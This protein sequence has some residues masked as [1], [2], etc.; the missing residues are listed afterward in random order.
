M[1][2]FVLVTTSFRKS[3]SLLP[4]VLFVASEIPLDFYLQEHY[5]GA[6][7]VAPWV[8]NS[9]GLL[10]HLPAVIQFVVGGAADALILACGTLWLSRL[11]AASFVR[12]KKS[13][14][15]PALIYQ[16]L[17]TPDRTSEHVAKPNRDTGFYVLR[18]IGLIYALYLAI[19]L[20]GSL[21]SAG[22]PKA[23][24]PLVDQSYE[25]IPLVIN[26]YVKLVLMFLL[27]TIAAYNVKLRYHAS[28]AMLVGHVV[29]VAA[30]LFFYYHAPAES[31]IGDLRL[32]QYHD[33]LLISAIADAVL[34]AIFVWVMIAHKDQAGDYRIQKQYPEFYSLPNRLTVLFFYAFGSGL[35][36]IGAAIVLARLYLNP[37]HGIGAI[38]GFPDPQICN[39]VTMYS[40]LAWLSITIARR[41]LLRNRFYSILTACFSTSLLASIAWLAIG[42]FIRTL[43]V[44]TRGGG[45]A[46]VDWYFMLNVALSGVVLSLLLGLRKMYYNVDYSI[47][48][49]SAAGA[50]NVMGMHGA[51]H[52]EDPEFDGIVLQSVDR[53]AANIRGRKRGLLNIPFALAEYLPMVTRLGS[54]FSSMSADERRYYLRYR[55]LR[56]PQEQKSAFCPE[57]ADLLYKIGTASHALVTLSHYN[58]IRSREVTNFVP[59]D[60]RDRLQGELASAPPPFVHPAAQ[61]TGPLAPQ[62][63]RPD[64][65]YGTQLVAPRMVTPLTEP[66]IPSEVDY[67]II[68]S[69]AGGAVMAYRLACEAPDAKIL[70]VERGPRYSPIQDFNDDE[71]DMVGKLY[72]EGGLQQT[73]RFDL[74]I[75]QAECMGG[76]TVIN[77][78]VTFEMPGMIRDKWTN[79]YGIDLTTVDLHYNQIASEIH[80]QEIGN[81]GINQAVSD[82][83]KKGIEGYEREVNTPFKHEYPLKANHLNMT[84]DGLCNIGNKKM[85]KRSMLETYIPWAEARGVQFLPETSAVRFSADGRRAEAVLLR[86]DLGHQRWVKV[87]KAVVVSGG[88]LAS[89]QFLLRSGVEKNVGQRLACN[90]ALPV[91]FEFPEELR[92]YDGVQITLGALDAN[93]RAVF[94]TYFNPPG[95]F[96]IS[97]PYYFDEHT[98]VMRNYP[99]ALNLGALVG[100]EPNGTIDP[101]PDILNGRAFTW[102]LGTTDIANIKYAL[103]TLARIGKHAGASR[104]V[105]PFDPGIRL[106]LQ[107]SGEVDQFDKALQEFPLRMSDIHL[108]TAHPQGGNGM[109]GESSSHKDQRVVDGKFRVEGYDNLFVADASLFPTGITVNPQW[110][111]MAM[112]SMASK[113]VLNCSSAASRAFSPRVVLPAVPMPWLPRRRRSSIR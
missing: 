63:F 65:P 45:H 77:N 83:F 111:I 70:V 34:A 57:L 2:G 3:S 44:A 7:R 73:K 14:P 62:N 90:I 112:S 1:L 84:G 43:A 4:I 93:S 42:P 68:G 86:T 20:L 85:R 95:A 98:R 22:F 25:N 80:I 37:T 8:F 107:K 105:F 16:N 39:S 31:Y 51:L 87:R 82:V 79:E 17:F 18:V 36:L 76:T 103:G 89:S 11:V 91:A 52:G 106:D 96:S 97:L 46:M 72:K 53:Q 99:H 35:A 27:A 49:L 101:Q 40:T 9:D 6:G 59:S 108:T 94:E 54:P 92:A 66:P 41:E 29:S 47:V 78:A 28:L 24:R 13:T 67:V 56:Q 64:T 15:A 32:T 50:Q 23:L 100:S 102:D 5:R 10:G 81:D 75:L 109:A 19:I 74:M 71:M 30:S 113:E 38:F 88:V 55:L 110:T 21:G 12:S 61:A 69:G 26:T 48:A 58:H 60:A 33:F 104:A